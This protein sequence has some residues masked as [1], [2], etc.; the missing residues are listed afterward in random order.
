MNPQLNQAITES[1]YVLG[2]S[3]VTLLTIAI[4]FGILAIALAIIKRKVDNPLY[5]TIPTILAVLALG[6]AFGGAIDTS[7]GNRLKE[8][9]ADPNF[10][11]TGVGMEGEKITS[12]SFFAPGQLK[13]VTVLGKDETVRINQHWAIASDPKVVE[14][15]LN[16]S[17]VST[18]TQNP[19]VAKAP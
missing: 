3:P 8:T 11:V 5:G 13:T 19:T 9:L 16:D 17:R 2:L 4:I 15:L 1:G 10:T 18:L 7:N 14:L 12:I 6:M